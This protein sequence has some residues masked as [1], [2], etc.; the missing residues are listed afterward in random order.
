MREVAGAVTLSVQEGFDFGKR[1]QCNGFENKIMFAFFRELW[2]GHSAKSVCIH[3][4]E[5]CFFV[6]R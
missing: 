6:R 1:V 3:E 5:F 4:C 2:L